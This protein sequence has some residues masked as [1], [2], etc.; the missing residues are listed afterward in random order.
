MNDILEKNLAKWEG[1]YGTNASERTL[2]LRFAGIIE[3]AY[4]QTGLGVVILVDEYDKPMLQAI[5]KK[6]CKKSSAIP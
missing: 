1:V 6:P 2:S 5:G 4:E 3:R